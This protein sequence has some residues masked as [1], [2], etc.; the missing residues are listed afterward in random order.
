[1]PKPAFAALLC[2]L[3]VPGAALAQV[4]K[5][6]DKAGRV[7]YTQTKP[8]GADCEG[9]NAVAPKPIGT[10]VN[11]LM[12]FS[13]E[14][15]ESRAAESKDQQKSERQQA[16]QEAR[17]RSARSREA[18]LEQVGRIFTVDEKGERHYQSDAQNEQTRQAARDAVARECG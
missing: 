12:Q 11:S 16:A 2:L 17:C 7:Q 18:A 10:D 15:D 6:K 9:M 5:C 4:Y 13:K 1:M 3:L 14:I 8:R